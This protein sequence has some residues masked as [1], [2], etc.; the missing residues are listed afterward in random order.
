MINTNIKYATNPRK[1][2]CFVTILSD[3]SEDSGITSDLIQN[4]CYFLMNIIKSGT[5]HRYNMITRLQHVD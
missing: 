1:A 4:F 5:A 2:P 3:L